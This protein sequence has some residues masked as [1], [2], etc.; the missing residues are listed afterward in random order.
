MSESF[1]RAKTIYIMVHKDALQKEL[2]AKLAL[3]DKL[4]FEMPYKRKIE[5]DGKKDGPFCQLCY[6]KDKKLFR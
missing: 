5:E 3:Q 1:V 4:E 6:D 2:K